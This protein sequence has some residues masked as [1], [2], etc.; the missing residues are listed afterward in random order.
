MDSESIKNDIEDEEN[1]NDN[2]KKT[3]DP[4]IDE[5]TEAPVTHPDNIN[6]NLKIL[7]E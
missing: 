7:M 1:K 3:G 5:L 2:K 4:N 6:G